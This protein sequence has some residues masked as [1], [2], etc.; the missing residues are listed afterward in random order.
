MAYD[1]VS[2]KRA[3]ETLR[4]RP[5]R[6]RVG[7]RGV[8]GRLNKFGSKRMETM[9]LLESGN[10][11]DNYNSEDIWQPPQGKTQKK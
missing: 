10:D 11:Y 1:N 8:V 7:E 9:H 4:Q 6:D 2:I 3:K 5:V